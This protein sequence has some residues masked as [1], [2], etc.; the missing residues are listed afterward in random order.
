MLLNLEK[1]VDERPRA[2]VGGGAI[3]LSCLGS[4]DN[5]TCQSFPPLAHLSTREAGDRQ[6]KAPRGVPRMLCQVSES[7]EEPQSSAHMQI[8]Q[9]GK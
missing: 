5:A 7:T 6:M 3:K 8:S 4:G 1:Q 2:G 9:R